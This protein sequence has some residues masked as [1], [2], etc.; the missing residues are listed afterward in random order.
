MEH[1]ISIEYLLTYCELHKTMRDRSDYAEAFRFRPTSGNEFNRTHIIINYIHTYRILDR[2][3]FLFHKIY[4][5]ISADHLMKIVSHT[6][7]R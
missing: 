3:F 7:N 6:T 5:S 4:Y 1:Q 2:Y